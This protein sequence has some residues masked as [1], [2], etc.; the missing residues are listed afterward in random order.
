MTMTKRKSSF[1]LLFGPPRQQQQQ[2]QQPKA[3]AQPIAALQ[4]SVVFQPEVVMR[5]PFMLH[6]TW[7]AP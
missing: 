4:H 6:G 3:A 1:E 7:S 2:Q 5:W